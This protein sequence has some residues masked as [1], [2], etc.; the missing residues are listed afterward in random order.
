MKKKVYFPSGRRYWDDLINS[1]PKKIEFID[2]RLNNINDDNKKQRKTPV[3]NF[4]KEKILSFPYVL[5]P[6]RIRGNTSS[7]DF[8]ISRNSFIYNATIPYYV[9]VEN[10]HTPLNYKKHKN[11]NIIW[12]QFD[13]FIN[14]NNF[15]GF[16]FYSKFSKKVFFNYYDKAGINIQPF[17]REVIYPYIVNIV[18]EGLENVIYKKR[19]DLLKKEVNLLY[20]SSI[21]YLKGGGEILEAIDYLKDQYNI[22]L[23]IVSDPNT[24]N[25]KDLR[26][27]EKEKNI[28][29]F[30][31]NLSFLELRE[32]YL[33][34]HMLVHPT[35]MDSSACVVL[36]AV[37]SFLPCIATKTFAIPEYIKDGFNGILFDNPFDAYTSEGELL[38]FSNYL[39][40]RNFINSICKNKRM[41]NVVQMLI[42][43]IDEITS[44]YEYYL[45]NSLDFY[46]QKKE[47][48]S[49]YI[50]NKWSEI[51]IDQL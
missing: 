7:Y 22:K 31:H 14:R 30:Q 4:L 33:N 49:E 50:L 34:S 3:R 24:I 48:K 35:Y 2:P 43:S 29:L 16:V 44:N 27:I 28:K 13:W 51:I 21:F 10:Y 12:K 32:I 18:D 26:Y 17:L 37:K 46:H 25:K 11:N 15:K 20:V 42:K 40:D 38:K 5:F 19:L 9:Y 6:Q 36:E 45:N 39:D 8:V 47:F 23:T 41:G 1:Q